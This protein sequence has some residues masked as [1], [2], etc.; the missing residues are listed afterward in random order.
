MAT[1]LVRNARHLVT[2]DGARRELENASVFVRD[3]V[4]EAIGTDCPTEADK[5]IDASRAIVTPGL[6]NTHHHLFQTLTRAVPAGQN[7]SLF[8]WLQA[9]YPIWATFG[10]EEMRISA[11][12]GLAE[13]VKSGCT[14]STD[15]CYLFPNGAHLS[16][17]IEG[18]G[19]VG[20]RFHATRG[21]MS[22]GQSNGGLPPDALVEDEAHILRDSADVVDRFHQR[23]PGAMVQVAIAPCSPFSVSRDLMRE[24]AILARDKGVMLHTHLAEDADDVRYSLEKFGCR[25]GDYARD[26]GWTGND[27]WHA[28]C[29]QLNEAEIDLFAATKT[30]VTHCPCSNCRLGSGVAPLRAMRD[31]GVPVGLGVDG[32]ASNDAADL[33]TEA[34][35]AMLL[36]RVARGADAFSAREALETA[37]RGGAAVLNRNDLGCLEVRKR[38]DFVLWDLEA[39][40]FAGCWDPVAALVLSAPHRA[41]S[42]YVEGRAILRDGQLMG[43]DERAL[44]EHATRLTA[45]LM[46]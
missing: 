37:T 25:P 18:A 39:L 36:Q 21:S 31:A 11:T 9:L 3:G 27:V 46:A 40:P 1:L 20:A 17:T 41:H 30:G 12:L 7:T 6:I 44:R 26:L 13:L 38:A 43:L 2:M 8:G 4:I 29:V 32:S 5:I 10:P 45:R 15:H 19:E 14:L 42:V 22:I 34:R 28:H 23:G 16:D 35:Q 33:L 24:A